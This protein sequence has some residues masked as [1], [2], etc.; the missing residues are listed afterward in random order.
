MN[1]LYQDYERNVGCRDLDFVMYEFYRKR[2][3]QS[4]GGCDLA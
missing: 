3:E 2:F 4:S 1:V